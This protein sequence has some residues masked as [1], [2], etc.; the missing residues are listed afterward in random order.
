MESREEMPKDILE[1]LA[2]TEQLAV[3]LKDLV[4]EKDA[5]LQQKEVELKVPFLPP[6]VWE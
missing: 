3:Q 5:Q 4:R 2:H 6:G 1:R